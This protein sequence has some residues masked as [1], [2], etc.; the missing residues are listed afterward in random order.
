MH[1][2]YPPFAMNN[3]S[4]ISAPAILR[5]PTIPV[6]FLPQLHPQ[7]QATLPRLPYIP[8]IAPVITIPINNVPKPTT[9]TKLLSKASD[10]I[11][12]VFVSKI[13]PSIEED[14]MKK[15]LQTCGFVISWLRAPNPSGGLGSFGYC[16]YATPDDAL[17]SLRILNNLTVDGRE[18]NLVVDEKTRKRLDEYEKNLI[19]TQETKEEETK[20]DLQIKKQISFMI[21]EREKGDSSQSASVKLNLLVDENDK[22]NIVSR[23]IRN[24]RERQAKMDYQRAEKITIEI[25]RDEQREKERERMRI[26]RERE[27]R[28]EFRE[29]ERERNLRRQERDEKEYRN[30]EKIIE[31]KER[32]REHDKRERE[33]EKKERE[34]YDRERSLDNRA[35]Y[36]SRRR[37][38]RG[39]EKKREQEEDEIDR[40]KELE[41]IRLQFELEAKRNERKLSENND[42]NNSKMVEEFLANLSNSAHFNNHINKINENK[43]SQNFNEFNNNN[44]N[45]TINNNNN[46]S[47]NNESNFQIVIDSF[48]NNES[49]SQLQQENANKLE[50]GFSSILTKPKTVAPVITAQPVTIFQKGN[51]IDQNI[52]P[53]RVLVP[54]DYTGIPNTENDKNMN[55]DLITSTVNNINNLPILKP[56][57]K[58]LID[59]IPT[60][61]SELLEYKINWEVVDKKNIIEDKMRPWISKKVTEYLGEKDSSLIEFILTQL[62]KY[63]PQKNLHDKFSYVFQEDTSIFIAKLLRKLIYEIVAA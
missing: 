61:L 63:E 33:R 11:I 12:K 10:K 30:R 18:L 54:L 21:A 19:I 60:E 26:E 49:N 37:S 55:I 40:K 35:E 32:E 46:N 6:P 8:P 24:F 20:S 36:D 51:E 7:M 9:I 39:R 50:F 42:E 1:P 5:P 15:L 13:S 41:E 58:A 27:R 44:N 34:R 16:E 25:T 14:F 2:F 43:D 53:K 62:H 3:P 17:R 56:D 23:E 48:I 59:S 38:V 47:N 52:K 45:S 22:A 57:I 4:I 28:R 31:L 29:S